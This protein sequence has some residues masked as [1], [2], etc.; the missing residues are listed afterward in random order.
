MSLR[1]YV[2]RIL[3]DPLPVQ[4][5]SLQY[6]GRL[7]RGIAPAR[8]GV[9]RASLCS[10]HF[11]PNSVD[12]IDYDMSAEIGKNS[13]PY[14]TVVRHTPQHPLANTIHLPETRVVDSCRSFLLLVNAE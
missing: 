11:R 5:Q 4:P 6:L 3:K 2:E 7:H 14:F 10:R 12:H 9:W 13:P 1:S 8:L